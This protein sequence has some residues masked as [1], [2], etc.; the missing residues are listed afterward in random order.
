MWALALLIVKGVTPLPHLGIFCYC[1]ICPNVFYFSLQSWQSLTLLFVWVLVFLFFFF[2]VM[3]TE[4]QAG[5]LFMTSCWPLMKYF[6]FYAPFF[7]A[8]TD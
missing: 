2:F 5:G 8:S 3:S 4:K 7:S 1:Q 6:I